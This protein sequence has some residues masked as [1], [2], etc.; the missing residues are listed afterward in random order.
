MKN[1]RDEE[2]EEVKFCGKR[3]NCCVYTTN[4]IMG[5]FWNDVI[6]III[7]IYFLFSFSYIILSLYDSIYRVYFLLPS[8]SSSFILSFSFS[9]FYFPSYCYLIKTTHISHNKLFETIQQEQQQASPRSKSHLYTATTVQKVAVAVQAS[10]ITVR[11]KFFFCLGS[12]FPSY[13]NFFSFP[14]F[15][16]T[17][18]M[19]VKKKEK[20]KFFSLQLYPQKMFIFNK[21]DNFFFSFSL[22]LT[23][24]QTC[25]DGWWQWHSRD[26]TCI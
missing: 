14:H 26:T 16:L 22:L 11:E 17:G 23:F 21:Y 24:T 18:F 20:R 4:G 2:Q 3:K 8:S 19:S 12:N 1:K 5:G 7:E 9:C 15:H 25:G 13:F 6:L 10:M